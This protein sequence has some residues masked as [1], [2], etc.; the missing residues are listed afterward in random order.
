MQPEEV[1]HA[2]RHLRRHAPRLLAARGPPRRH[3]RSTTSR[4]RSASRT[5]R[6][7]AASSSPSARTWS[8]SKL[9]VEAYND[10]MVDEWCGDSDGRLIPLC[11]VPLWDVELAAAEI[12]R[13]AARGVRAVACSELPAWLGLP[14]IHSGYWDPFFQRLRGDRH[15]HLHAHR[16]GHQDRRAPRPTRRPSSPPNM[17]AANSVGV[18]DRLALLGQARAVPRTSSCSTPS[19]RSAGSPTSSSGPTTP[20]ETHQWA[21]GEAR[22]R[23]PPSHVLP[24]AASTAA[25][26][27]T[28]SASSCSTRSALDN[29]MFETDYPHQDGTFPAVTADR[30]AAL[31]PPRTRADPQAGPGQRHPAPRPGPLSALIASSSTPHSSCSTQGSD[32]PAHH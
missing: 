21:Q 14:S 6:A 5:T 29:V 19:A 12:R 8:S 32:H 31:R 28:R 22:C 16:V 4:P 15:R 20:G 27:R 18:D 3:G 13:N 26:S 7:S 24:P 10:W 25:S 30:R 11:I 1:D 23:E 17:I 2:G 9:C